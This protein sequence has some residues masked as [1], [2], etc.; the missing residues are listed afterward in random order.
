[1]ANGNRKNYFTRGRDR[2][3]GGPP[4]MWEDLFGTVG[5]D[6]WVRPSGQGFGN[7]WDFWGGA[8]KRGGFLDPQGR[9]Q[10]KL[11]SFFGKESTSTHPMSS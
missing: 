6:A 3:L 8:T 9:F 2:D 7:A 4:S 11:G 5:P 1:M 10:Q